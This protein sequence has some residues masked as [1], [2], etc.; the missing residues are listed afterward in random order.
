MIAVTLQYEQFPFVLEKCLQTV[1][2]TT[3]QSEGC[4][5]SVPSR[6]YLGVC[7][8]EG[9][10]LR[11]TSG[12]PPAVRP[13]AGSLPHICSSVSVRTGALVVHTQTLKR[14][15]NNRTVQ[16]RLFVPFYYMQLCESRWSS[17]RG[18]RGRLQKH[19]RVGKAAGRC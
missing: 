17:Q 10:R 14:F 18:W 2:S 4:A 6:G 11:D 13:E 7:K 3:A 15:N 8:K 5:A 9:Q 1:S 12:L 19:I 16:Q